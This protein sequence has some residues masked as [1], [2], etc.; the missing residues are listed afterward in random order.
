MLQRGKYRIYLQNK[1][2]ENSDAIQ[3]QMQRRLK[4]DCQKVC[5][6]ENVCMHKKK[7]KFIIW[8]R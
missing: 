5:N 7:N 3:T 8:L 2:R 1:V 6:A 4:N